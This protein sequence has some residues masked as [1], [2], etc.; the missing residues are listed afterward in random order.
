MLWFY[1]M[2]KMLIIELWYIEIRTKW[3][4]DIL[5]TMLSNNLF[6]FRIQ[7]HWSLFLGIQLINSPFGVKPLPNDKSIQCSLEALSTE[8]L[9]NAEVLK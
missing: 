7:F 6:L 2:H 1:K 5:Q 3:M 8:L 9:Q 4:A